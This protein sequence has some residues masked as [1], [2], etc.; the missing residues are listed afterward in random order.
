MITK[1]FAITVAAGALVL[2]PA[3]AARTGSSGQPAANGAT[4]VSASFAHKG[5]VWTV[6]ATDNGAKDALVFTAV[7]RSGASTQTHVYSF[8]SGVVFSVA[9]NLSSATLLTRLGAYGTMNAR[10]PRDGT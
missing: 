4:L 3:A 1:V 10:F 6:I 8:S 5:Y 9:K 7:R 2:A